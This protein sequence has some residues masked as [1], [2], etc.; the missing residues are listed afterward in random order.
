MDSRALPMSHSGIVSVAIP[1][2][3]DASL[4]LL[5][6][7]LRSPTAAMSYF[8]NARS[9]G[10]SFLLG[11]WT[12]F[13]TRDLAVSRQHANATELALWKNPRP[14][15]NGNPWGKVLG[16]PSWVFEVGMCL[17]DVPRGLTVVPPAGSRLRF[18]PVVTRSSTPPK[19]AS[20][21]VTLPFSVTELPRVTFQI[22]YLHLRSHLSLCFWGN[23]NQPLFPPS[24]PAIQ[25]G[26]AQCSLSLPP[27]QSGGHGTHCQLRLIR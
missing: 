16:A 23:L 21:S 2:P 10:L 1:G 19:P 26:R 8:W 13:G 27:S 24:F 18:S 4:R 11:L 7:P 14:M 22:S 12:L 3:I 6:P 15:G 17:R 25:G 20:F 5:S 9:A